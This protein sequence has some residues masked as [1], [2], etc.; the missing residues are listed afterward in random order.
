MRGKKA[1]LIRMIANE[2]AFANTID[3]ETQYDAKKN[4]RRDD[5]VWSTR[6]IV[7]AHC[8]R[9]IIKQVKKLS[10]AAK[11]MPARIFQRI[12]FAAIG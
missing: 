3:A 12:A 4:T 11:N 10:R 2:I 5:L 8:E 9:A 6:T 7:V 1:K